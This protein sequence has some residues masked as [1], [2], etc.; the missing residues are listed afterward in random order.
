MLGGF[1]ITKRK[2]G[3]EEKRLL[4]GHSSE[5]NTSNIAKSPNKGGYSLTSRS[6]DAQYTFFITVIESVKQIIYHG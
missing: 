1:V 3:K 5:R 2:K 4:L 6:V